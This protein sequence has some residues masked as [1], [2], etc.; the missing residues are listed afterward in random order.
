MKLSLTFV[1]PRHASRIL[2][3]S[4]GLRLFCLNAPVQICSIR[5]FFFVVF[6]Q[7]ATEIVVLSI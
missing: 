1:K 7:F 6:M 2:F 3:Q 5:T 4:R